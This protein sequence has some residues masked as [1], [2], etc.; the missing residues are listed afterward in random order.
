MEASGHG[1]AHASHLASTHQISHHRGSRCPRWW[2][3][4]PQSGVRCQAASTWQLATRQ[5]RARARDCLLTPT[6]QRRGLDSF[7]CPP[8]WI[9]RP[10]TEWRNASGPR[11]TARLP[12]A[13]SGQVIATSQGT[14]WSRS[15]MPN[16]SP[17]ALRTS[18]PTVPSL[19]G[20]SSCTCATTLHAAT[21][22]ISKLAPR[23]RT[24][25]RCVTGSDR[26]LSLPEH[27]AARDLATRQDADASH[28][29]WP[30]ASIS[31]IGDNGVK[32]P[33]AHFPID[34]SSRPMRGC[35]GLGRSLV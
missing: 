29:C 14:G 31:E 7:L 4:W 21:L 26:Q 30:I 3:V 23:P 25:P 18:S 13:G 28:A 17:I 1:W 35:Q 34:E 2:R 11:S 22:S 6:R 8:I 12:T 10:S 5:T 15:V 19:L 33:V 16:T 32:L 27:H 20:C 9:Q 24:W